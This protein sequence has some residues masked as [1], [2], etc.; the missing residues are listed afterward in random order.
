MKTCILR[1]VTL[2]VN[3]Q[4][5][6]MSYQVIARKYRPQTFAEVVGQKHITQ[7]LQNALASERVHHAYLF[8]GARGVGKTTVARILAKTLNCKH[9][10]SPAGEG[11]VKGAEPCNI[12]E[13]CKQVM[14]GRSIDVMEIDGAS[15]TGVDD[16]RQIREQ[17]KYM[18]AEGKYKIYIIDEVHMLSTQAFNAL[19][20]TL[21]EPPPHVIFIFA[22]T[23]VRKIPI[24]ILS[25]CQRFDFRHIAL[26][27]LAV[28]LEKIAVTE[29]IECSKE[30]LYILA[31][32][33]NGSL[34]DAQSLFDQ[35]IAFSG[36]KIEYENLQ[37]MF[38]F[39]D[40]TEFKNLV[41]SILKKDRQAALDQFVR[42][43]ETGQD[44][45]RLAVDLLETFRSLLLLKSL[46]EVPSWLELPEEESKTLQELAALGTVEEFDQL[47][48]LTYRGAQE[49]ARSETPR[50]IFEV[51]LIRM[52]LIDRVVPVSEILAKLDKVA[53]P[54]APSLAVSQREP[55]TRD[56]ASPANV[57]NS[58]NKTW[59][60]FL[61][62][63]NQEKPQL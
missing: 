49:I 37:K 58:S 7:T 27:D 29:K 59:E 12:C 53:G 30:A 4:V 33:G 2:A 28:S 32:E 46:G 5:F 11:G 57:S 35:A 21:E 38:G 17:T 48:H 10:I 16:V 15:N 34:R 24:T 26:Q 9:S 54:A 3:E 63:L 52:T 39:L 18:P 42:F 47:F 50:M 60:Q 61:T 25:R 23:E 51:L 36:K 62:W 31:R 19:L 43:Y 14:D 8:T 55:S 6:E 13:N 40:R 44:C 41:S 20:K 1:S 45:N 22:T 56:S